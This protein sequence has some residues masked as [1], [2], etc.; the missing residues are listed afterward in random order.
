MGEALLIALKFLKKST[1]GTMTLSIETNNYGK[2]LANSQPKVIKHESEYDSALE[3]VNALMSRDDLTPE[4]IELLQVWAILIEDYE[5]K[6]HPMPEASPHDILIHLMEA[7]ELRQ[8]DL[9]GTLGAKGVVSEVVNGKR[10][11]SNAQAKALGEFFKVD[12]AL[13]I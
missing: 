4:E 5:E 11:I 1:Q 7:R 9:I 6:Y 8:A 2:L 13:F 12:P 10:S 3:V